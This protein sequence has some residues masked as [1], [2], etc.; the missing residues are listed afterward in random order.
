MLM[1]YEACSNKYD[2]LPREKYLKTGGGKR[3]LQ[4]RLEQSL[5]ANSRNGTSVGRE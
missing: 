4:N 1:D 3:Y 5:W 2:A